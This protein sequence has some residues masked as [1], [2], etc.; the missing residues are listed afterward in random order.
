MPLDIKKVLIIGSGPTNVGIE[1]EFDASG[2]ERLSALRKTGAKILLIDNN[3]FSVM[4]EEIQAADVFV[5]EVNFTNVV[6]IIEREHPDAIMPTNGGLKAMQIAWQLSESGV[7]AENNVSLVG[8]RD[9]NLS[10]V[11]ENVE[12]KRTL[13]QINERTIESVIVANEDEAIDFVRKVDFPVIVKPISPNH[14]TSRFICNNTEELE[15]ALEV[16]FKRTYIKRC[17]IEQSIVGYKEIEMVGIRDAQGNKV[18]VSGLEDMDPIGIHSGDSIIFA[19]TQTLLNEEYQRLRTATFR[20]MDA[21]GITGTCHVQ[22]AQHRMENSHFVTKVSPYFTRN[23]ALAAKATGYPLSYVATFLELGYSLTEI[24]LPS[25]YNKFMGIMEPTT[26]HIVVRVPIWPFEDIEDV[27]QH[28]NTIMKSVG[29]T[30]GVG[31][32]VEEAIIKALHSSQLS[33]RDILPSV[34][35]VNDDELIN[36]LIHPLAS[37]M[38]IL[39]EALRRGFSIDELSELTKV[40]KF[41]FYKLNQLLKAQDYVI[42]HPLSEHS[43]EVGHRYGFGD[44]MLAELWQVSIS[45]IIRMNSNVSHKITFKGIEPTGGELINNTNVFYSSYENENESH[46][47]ENS[48]VALVIG[49]GGN[50]LGPNT[51]ADYYTAQILIQL[52]KTGY[53]TII[54]NT[55]PNAVSLAPSISDKQYIEPI[56]LGN[57]LSIVNLEHPDVIFLPGNR[58]FLS[59]QLKKFDDLNVVILPPDQKTSEFNERTVSNAVDF[60]ID[61][62][63]VIPITTVSFSNPQGKNKLKFLTQ[64]QIPMTNWKQDASRL[65]NLAINEINPNDWQGLVQVLYNKHDDEFECIGIRPMTIT[66]TT[67]LSKVTGIDWISLLVKKYLNI[68]STVLIEEELRSFTHKR[69]AYLNAVFPFEALQSSLTDGTIAQEIGAKISYQ[70]FENYQLD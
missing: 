68:D 44:G 58:H 3:P 27:D 63:N 33:P 43:I 55:N 34:S 40:D 4:A 69:F 46:P 5:L 53:K 30:I 64:I 49:R 59:N 13:T 56:Q 52:R 28:L 26:D 15:E 57:I 47:F 61:G 35:K 8:V 37:R 65:V 31:R 39:M 66:E 21:L 22:F 10:K 2:L 32:T 6:N 7:L 62:E 60:F 54:M 67:F 20:I 14:D 29:S 16:S 36:Q 42:D 24:K 70:N 9:T 18:L 12:L 51:G 48:K 11:V 25:R 17:S 45:T 23:T 1:N 50:Q 41:Y 38:L 19:P